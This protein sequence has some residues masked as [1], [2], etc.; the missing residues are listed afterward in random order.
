MAKLPNLSN[1]FVAFERFDRLLGEVDEL[2]V[3]VLRGHLLLE[4]QLQRLLGSAAPAP[5]FVEEANLR[6]P[7]LLQLVR[8]FLP[9]ETLELVWRSLREL[10]G[11]RNQLAHRLEPRDLEARVNAFVSIIRDPIASDA[12][13]DEY[14]RALN[15]ALGFLYGALSHLP[16]PRHAAQQG[17][18]ADDAPRRG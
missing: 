11:L 17:D 2:T 8:A 7:Q 15:Q 6:F 10:N 16:G 3:A 4:E 5:A 9:D 1:P 14:T 13:R 18:A 12:S